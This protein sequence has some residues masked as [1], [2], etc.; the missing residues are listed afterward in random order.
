M[1]HFL[2]FFSQ[3]C[4]RKQNESFDH[5]R[6]QLSTEEVDE[7]QFSESISLLIET[8]GGNEECFEVDS[9]PTSPLRLMNTDYC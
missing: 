3:M 7:S 6:M 8:V 2:H 4:T 5:I 1:S 9:A